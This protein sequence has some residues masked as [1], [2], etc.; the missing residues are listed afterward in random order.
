M[1]RLAHPL[2]QKAILAYRAGERDTLRMLMQGYELSQAEKTLIEVRL[3]LRDNAPELAKS[4]LDRFSPPSPFLTGEKE[5]LLAHY[6]FISGNFEEAAA[7]NI[8]AA[9]AYRNAKDQEGEFSATY[10]LSVD[11]NRMGAEVLSF[12][13]LNVAHSLALND[14]HRSVIARGFACHFSQEENFSEAIDWLTRAMEHAG[15]LSVNDRMT[16]FCVAADIYFRAGQGQKSLEM[17][18]ILYKDR[19]KYR[20]RPR[21]EFEF[22]VLSAFLKGAA[23]ESIPTSV[24]LSEEYSL[25]WKI[26]R[27]VQTGELAKA[28]RLWRRLIQVCPKIYGP[29]F[30]CLLPSEEKTIFF[31][32]FSKWYRRKSE[33]L[34]SP[35]FTPKGRLGK[36][37][38]ALIQAQTPLSKEALIEKIW[39]VSYELQYDTRFYKLVERLKKISPYPIRVE[40]RAYR[41]EDKAQSDAVA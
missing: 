13:Y 7:A 33:T 1:S 41:Y 26:I 34:E 20:D 10:N 37:H 6:Y 12:H 36:L 9:G 17:L 32:C 23:L 19:T 25:K 31:Q 35:Q 27:F 8:R 39:G 16:L 21:I 24:K 11:F 29:D 38:E 15:Q 40:N 18:A 22:K 2:Y 14:G 30:G 5:V 28:E 4:L 3:A